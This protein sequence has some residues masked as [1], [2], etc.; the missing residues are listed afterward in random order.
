MKNLKKSWPRIKEKLGHDD[1]FLLLL[2]YDGTLTPIVKRPGLAE[3]SRARFGI[4]K[5]LS[6]SSGIVLS[7]IS[8]RMLSDIRRKIPLRGVYFVGNHGLEIEGEG[9]RMTVP[10]ALRAKKALRGIKE[11][12]RKK[13]GRV[14]GFVIEDKKLTLSF[15]YRLVRKADLFQV[16]EEIEEAIRPYSKKRRIRVTYGKKVIEV[17]PPVHWNKGHAVLW[18]LRK[19]LKGKGGRKVLPIY[20]GDDRTDEDAFKALKE[21]GIT[22]L[23]GM[24]KSRAEYYVADVRGTYRFLKQILK[25]KG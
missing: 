22:V 23:V 6:K 3:L 20:M 21:K 12:V 1:I 14:K 8:G 7:I 5:K 15:H 16:L 19:T 4:L 2:D 24:G 10:E 18:V 17:R 13:L 11:K 9:K 25:V